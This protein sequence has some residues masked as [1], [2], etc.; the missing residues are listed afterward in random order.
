MTTIDSPQVSV[1]VNSFNPRG[2]SRLRSMTEFA[3]RCYRASTPTDHELILVDG[4]ATRDARLAEICDELGYRYLHQGRRLAFAEGYNAG[5][6]ESRAPWVVLAASDIFVVPGWLEKLL[7]EANRTGAWMAAPYLSFSDYPSQRLQYV[8]SPQTFVPNHLTFNLNLISR[9]CIEE[10]GLLDEQFS[11]C[12]NDVDYVLRIRAAGGEVILANCGEITHLGSATLSK[13][14]LLAMHERDWPRFEAKWPGAWDS[15]AL[16]LHDRGRRLRWLAAFLRRV[17]R[18][19]RGDLRKMLY[20]FEPWLASPLGVGAV[21][22]IPARG[23]ERPS[24]NP[25]GLERGAVIQPPAP[26][27]ASS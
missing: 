7:A 19:W 16:R 6:A 17:P 3:L 21:P 13:S 14:A 27:S 1:V 25:M 22:A 11:G 8:V 2:D 24:L 5:M 10:V 18:R 9:Q 15:D 23:L 4:S 12:F 26:R 20:R